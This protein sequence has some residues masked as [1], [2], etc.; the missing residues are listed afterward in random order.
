[1][2]GIVANC[3]IG[4]SAI[5]NAIARALEFKDKKLHERAAC[6]LV[7]SGDAIRNRMAETC[8]DVS[9]SLSSED[10]ASAGSE[11]G[12]GAAGPVAIV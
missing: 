3:P 7:K 9:I 4:K 5:P 10:D 12:D 8:G 6:D 2:E 11:D 1:M